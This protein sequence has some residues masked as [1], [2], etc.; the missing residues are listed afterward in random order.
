M[1]F[2]VALALLKAGKRVAREGWNGK[3]MFIYLVGPGRY[4]ATTVA[5]GLIA[6]EQP[7]YLVPYL[8]YIAM[9]TVDGMVVPWLASQTDMLA[10]D[11]RVSEDERI[12]L[13][14]MDTVAAQLDTELDATDPADPAN[15]EDEDED[16]FGVFVIKIGGSI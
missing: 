5:G 6:R 12:D 13:D 14:V 7:D 4:P 1:N 2:G 16:E 15:D 10:S 8:P 11:W 9:K 3:G